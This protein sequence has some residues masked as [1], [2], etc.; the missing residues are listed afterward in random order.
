MISV[1][2]IVL[3]LLAFEASRRSASASWIMAAG[4]TLA[5]AA[6][7][8]EAAGL[9]ALDK[10]LQAHF[11]AEAVP[12][13]TYALADLNGDGQLDAVVMM[14]D[15]DYCGS[16][17]CSLGVL[18]GTKKSFVFVSESSIS[19][20]PI[21]VLRESRQGWKSLSVSVS[22]GGAQPGEAIMR[23]NGKR[24]PR[25]PSVQPLAKAADLAGATTLEFKK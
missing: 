2:A 8:S 9:P 22:G 13:Y 14:S 7:I 25:N 23:F 16:G 10:V 21:R 3:S 6:G 1:L 17:G 18:R 11:K 19:N 24:Y 12:A 5:S 4:L 20:E 15:R